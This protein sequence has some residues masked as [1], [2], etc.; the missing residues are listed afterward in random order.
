MNLHEY[1]AKA[2]LTRYGLKIPKGKVA[3]TPEE[4]ETAAREIGPG[5]WVLKA[6]VHA[7]GRGKAGGIR[8][9]RDPADV[10]RMAEEMIGMRLVTPQSGAQGNPV[11]RVLVE[12]D[13][14]SERE[15]YLGVTI[16]RARERVAVIGS[17]VGGME[18][19]EV[20]EHSPE[21]I[22]T[23]LIDPGCGLTNFQGRRLAMDLGFQGGNIGV[24]A[25]V[26]SSLYRAFIE[27]DCSLLEINPLAL[28]R[29]G[30][31]VALDAKMNIDDN[32][33]Y[34]HP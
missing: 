27:N 28:M 30:A 7:G 29:S 18:I 16:D 34:R 14:P 12:E 32:A 8:T 23:L 13:L 10:R 21:K 4:A 5:P 15:L 31:W 3:C 9:A 19:E 17:S 26:A 33:L 1:Q 20:S 22:H 24:G 11:S 6:Q 2:I 25:A